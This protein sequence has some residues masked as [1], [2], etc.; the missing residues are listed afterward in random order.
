MSLMPHCPP[1]PDDVDP[2]VIALEYEGMQPLTPE[3]YDLWVSRSGNPY[4]SGKAKLQDTFSEHKIQQW[5]NEQGGS[6]QIALSP[7]PITFDIFQACAMKHPPSSTDIP[8]IAEDVAKA[9]ITTFQVLIF[10]L[11]HNPNVGTI[12]DGIFVANTCGNC[13]KDS[14]TKTCTRCKK[15]K[16]CDRDCQRSHWQ[17]HKRQCQPPV[18]NV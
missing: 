15:M 1:I 17:D 13:G 5:F 16:Y 14:P 11:P 8:G 9:I 6:V 18:E 3:E 12:E 2:E 10:L 7:D 4:S